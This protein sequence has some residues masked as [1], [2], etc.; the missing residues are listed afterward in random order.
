MEKVITKNLGIMIVAVN[1]LFN[2]ACF[3]HNDKTA[4][5]GSKNVSIDLVIGNYSNAQFKWFDLI[6][7]RAH[8]DVSSLKMC[9]KRLRFK[10]NDDSLDSSNDDSLDSSN[11]D[12]LD[13]SNDD[14]LDS[15]NDDSLDSSSDDSLDSSNDDDNIDFDLGEVVLN[16]SGTFLSEIT[17]P[18]GVYKRIEFDLEGNC[19]SG[20]SI[21]LINDNGTFSSNDRITIKFSGLFEANQDAVLSLGIQ[22]IMD[23]LNA[24]NGSVSL[25]DTAE[26][27]SGELQ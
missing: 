2:V 24:H 4:V 21:E 6:T 17:I 5:S 3:D 8:A 1:L 10:L 13:S 26:E 25:K 19:A 22:N 14:S 16:P 11:D 27:I 20:K 9:F 23:Q 18:E 12:S 7:P 15:S